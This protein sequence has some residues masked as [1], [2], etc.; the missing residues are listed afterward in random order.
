MPIFSYRT[1]IESLS[2][3][4]KKIAGV[5]IIGFLFSVGP[6]RRCYIVRATHAD[7]P[8]IGTCL[9]MVLENDETVCFARGY[10]YNIRHH[11]MSGV[12]N[13]YNGSLIF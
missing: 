2:L 9:S 5:F 4:H 11:A 8:Q 1:L 13:I 12:A 10:H 3:L 7:S 6:R